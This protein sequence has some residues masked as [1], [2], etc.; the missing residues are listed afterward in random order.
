MHKRIEKL[1]KDTKDKIC[2]QYIFASFASDLDFANKYLIAAYWEN[3]ASTFRQIISSWFEKGKLLKEEFFKN[4]NLDLNNPD[5]ETEFQQHEA[6]LE[7]TQIRAT[8]TILVNGYELPDNYKI[9]DLR[10]F[11]ALAIDV[12]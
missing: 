10:Y 4:L 2:V 5:I 9:E 1:L 3:D 11:T 12:D 7:K 8:P 6:W